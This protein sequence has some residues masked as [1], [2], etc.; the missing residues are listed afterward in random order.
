MGTRPR[1]TNNTEATLKSVSL[2]PLLLLLLFLTNKSRQAD[3]EARTDRQAGGGQGSRAAMRMESRYGTN[4][5]NK[6]QQEDEGEMPVSLSAHG[7]A[8]RHERRRMAAGGSG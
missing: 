8:A 1:Q 3:N 7:D 5:K 4:Q 6:K 2:S